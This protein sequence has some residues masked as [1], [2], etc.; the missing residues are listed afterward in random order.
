MEIEDTTYRILVCGSRNW[1]DEDA[2]HAALFGWSA[3]IG[4]HVLGV[5]SGM[6]KGADAH[7]ANWARTF[8]TPLYEFHADWAT[9]GKAA[10]TIRNLRMLNVGK[11]N[12]VL[13]FSDN[14]AES[15]GT[16]HMVTVSRRAGV[17]VHLISRPVLTEQISLPF[18]TTGNKEKE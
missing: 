10:G 11:P 16:R 15:R 18:G 6:A 17:P 5:I 2:V 3:M 13:A 14:L 8:K 4:D 12:Q 7:A 9:F 1:D